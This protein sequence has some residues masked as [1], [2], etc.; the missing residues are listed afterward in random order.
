MS[1]HPGSPAYSPMASRFRIR[2]DQ[3]LAGHSSTLAKS[4][5][6]L[7]LLNAWSCA[8]S[9]SVLRRMPARADP[10]PASFHELGAVQ[11]NRSDGGSA[12]RR[13]TDD[14][15]PFRAPAEMV[16]P[17]LPPR[18]EEA[19]HLA[20]VRIGGSDPVALVVIAH[21][22]CRPKV[23]LDSEPAQRLGDDVVDLHG[24]ACD[25]RR[26]QTVAT[27]VATLPGD[28]VAQRPPDVATAHVLRATARRRGPAA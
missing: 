8:T 24:S 14:H 6:N 17:S 21:G 3:G 4:G 15:V 19:H 9:F 1:P 11:T 20:R 18:I 26:G 7:R 25:A 16:R 28:L 12:S 10:S 5:A 27:A 13:L 2:A 22:A 23:L